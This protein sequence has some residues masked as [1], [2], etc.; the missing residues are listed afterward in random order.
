[1]C[2]CAVDNELGYNVNSDFSVVSSLRYSA[3]S[4]T[5][6]LVT[7][8]VHWLLMLVLGTRTS[9]AFCHRF[10]SCERA[11]ARTLFFH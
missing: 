4:S 7:L 6:Q 9:F 8:I 10:C 5:V 11:V 3:Q 1:M 2:F